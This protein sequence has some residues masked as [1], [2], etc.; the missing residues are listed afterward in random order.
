LVA[1][2]EK[3]STNMGYKHDIF[4]SYRRDP[5]TLRWIKDHFVPLL[6][7]HLGFELARSPVIY[8]DEQI[9]SGSSWPLSLGRALG[10][11]R[12]LIALWT[13]NYFTSRWCTEEFGQMLRREELLKLRTP[14]KP[15]GLIIP[16]FIHDGSSFPPKLQY[17]QRFEIQACFNPRMAKDSP[18]AEA[19]AA[20]LAAEAPAI[21]ASIKNAPAWRKEWVATAATGFQKQ[22]RR[23]A[24]TQQKVPRFTGP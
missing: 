24:R 1:A 22:F 7:L 10:S 11:S 9:D 15:N 18:R 12:V 16:A 19:L 21:A 13:A 20:A 17:I 23:Q 2:T 4:V 5:E 3:T 8:L 14:K 6:S